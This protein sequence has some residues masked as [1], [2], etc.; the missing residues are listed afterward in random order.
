MARTATATIRR[1]ARA[2]R[3][4]RRPFPAR[5]LHLVDIENLAGTGLPAEW[6]VALIRRAYAS[7]VGIGEMDQVVIGCNHNGLP[8]AA[9]GW[10][11]ARYLVRSGPDGADAELLA[12]ISGEN[13]AARFTDVVIGSGDG[14]FTRATAALAA[15]GPRVTVV[16]RRAGLARTLRLAAQNVIYLD[17]PTGGAAAAQPDAA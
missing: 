3:T 14:A 8:S 9:L 16:S 10:P 7:R 5:T 6:E 17:S 4:A 1:A 12:V 13:V 11:G 15:A 2:A